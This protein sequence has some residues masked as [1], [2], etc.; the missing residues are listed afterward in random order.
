MFVPSLRVVPGVRAQ[1]C[2]YNLVSSLCLTVCQCVIS[3][4]AREVDSDAF[5]ERPKACCHESGATVRHKR[6]RHPVEANLY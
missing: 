6:L 3:S 4:G 5:G 2:S 1:I